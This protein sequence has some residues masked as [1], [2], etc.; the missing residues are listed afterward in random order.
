MEEIAVFSEF[1]PWRFADAVD[2]NSRKK[3]EVSAILRS[4]MRS[5]RCHG[6]DNFDLSFADVRLE[7]RYRQ[8]LA[9]LEI[10]QSFLL[11]NG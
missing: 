9:S 5:R 7:R 8:T 2:M 10:P 3:K 1:S 6:G 4:A 11:V